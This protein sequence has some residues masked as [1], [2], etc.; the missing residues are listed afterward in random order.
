M[1]VNE[2][3]NSVPARNTPNVNINIFLYSAIPSRQCFETNK[4]F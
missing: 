3:P 2:V 4:V 1:S